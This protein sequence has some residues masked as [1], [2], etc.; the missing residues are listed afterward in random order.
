MKTKCKTEG[1]SGIKQTPHK[2]QTTGKQQH[3]DIKIFKN[4]RSKKLLVSLQQHTAVKT[5]SHKN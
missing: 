5:A 4:L 3:V 2:T 1:S